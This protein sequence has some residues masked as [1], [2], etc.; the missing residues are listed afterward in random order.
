MVQV[1]VEEE[2]LRRLVREESQAAVTAALAA[3]QAPPG[4]ITAKQAGVRLAMSEGAVRRAG[5]RGELPVVKLPSGRVRYDAAALDAW[6]R[7]V[8]G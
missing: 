3:S 7:S 4:L 2:A 1:L 6:A 5:Q 8:C